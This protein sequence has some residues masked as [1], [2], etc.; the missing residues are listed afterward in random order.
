MPIQ[1]IISCSNYLLAEGLLKLL[2][3]D[4]DLKSTAIYNCQDD[5]KDITKYKPDVILSD[6]DSCPNILQSHI[7]DNTKILLIHNTS[8]AVWANMRMR[9]I[10]TK[11]VVGILPLDTTSEILIKAIK[12]VY[13][14]E[15][16]LNRKSIKDIVC[17]T[18][19][20]INLTGQEKEIANY[21]CQGYKN[22][23]IANKL[24][25]SEQT[26]KSHCNR[27][28][29]KLG[30]KDRLQLALSILHAEN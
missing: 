30:V 2:E 15:L 3:N 7:H 27:I 11:G 17:N 23:D 9:E 4:R 16:W 6:I 20:E 13:S 26:V 1:V 18:G 28:Y 8:Q 5:I 19:Q 22:K 29:K 21:I 10:L 12:A 24:N 25:I 14:G